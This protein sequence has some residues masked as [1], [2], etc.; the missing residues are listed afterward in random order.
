MGT[1]TTPIGDRP[2]LTH[3]FL[4][5]AHVAAGGKTSYVGVFDRVYVEGVPAQIPELTVAAAL[6]GP[7]GARHELQVYFRDS[8]GSDVI[9]PI[10]PLPVMYSAYGTANAHVSIRGLPIKKLGFFNIGL[11]FENDSIGSC[12]L[13]VEPRKAVS[14]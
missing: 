3:V 11:M 7:P 13:Y 8:L 4:C 6:S 10:G 2:R 9:P 12:V 1:V 14:A 5:D